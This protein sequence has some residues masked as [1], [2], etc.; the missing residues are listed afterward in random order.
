MTEEASP[1]IKA[2]RAKYSEAELTRVLSVL[3]RLVDS[4]GATFSDAQLAVSVWAIDRSMLNSLTMYE[5]DPDAT[6]VEV[7]REY[8]KLLDMC[9]YYDGPALDVSVVTKQM[10]DRTADP[11]FEG[12]V[13]EALATIMAWTKEHIDEC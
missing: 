11:A 9:S 13:A 10:M 6:L 5:V 7:L 4:G 2:V 3:Q 8:R 1:G 12:R